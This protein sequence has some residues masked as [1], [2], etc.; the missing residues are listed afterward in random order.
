[1]QPMRTPH[2]PAELRPHFVPAQRAFEGDWVANGPCRKPELTRDPQLAGHYGYNNG[3]LA[4]YDEA[5]DA[6]IASAKQLEMNS[7]S[8][9]NAIR[10]LESAGFVGTGF[11][12]VPHSNDGGAFASKMWPEAYT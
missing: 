12:F 4:V 9:D 1:M 8:L 7:V 10:I 3:I 6:F 5:G 11:I 2:I